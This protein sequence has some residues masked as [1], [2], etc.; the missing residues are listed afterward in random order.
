MPLR[1]ASYTP[2]ARAC[3]NG[4]KPGLYNERLPNNIFLLEREKQ[5]RFIKRLVKGFRANEESV[6]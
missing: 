4:K 5:V 1:R 6:P 3:L 2:Q